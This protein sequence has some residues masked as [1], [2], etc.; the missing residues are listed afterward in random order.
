MGIWWHWPSKQL[1]NVCGN[2]C[3]SNKEV[4]ETVWQLFTWLLVKFASSW[5]VCHVW[6]LGEF[7][8]SIVNSSLPADG[9][10]MNLK[11]CGGEQFWPILIC[12]LH[13]YVEEERKCIKL[14]CLNH[15]MW[16]SVWE[17]FCIKNLLGQSQC[18]VRMLCG[19]FWIWSRHANH[20]TALFS[21]GKESWPTKLVH[22]SH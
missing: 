2:K 1:A 21:H 9:R 18:W 13:I 12:F 17:D 11:A 6:Q 15:L 22:K 20:L 8:C 19:I 14:V 4:L 5:C 10:M 7:G 3:L 16:L